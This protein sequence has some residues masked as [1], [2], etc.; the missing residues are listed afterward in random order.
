M[1]RK[2]YSVY[3]ILEYSANVEKDTIREYKLKAQ[4]VHF[5]FLEI[6]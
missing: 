6:C 3:S 2:F 1:K 5:L 4:R